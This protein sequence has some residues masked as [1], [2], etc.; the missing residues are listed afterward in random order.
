MAAYDRIECLLPLVIVENFAFFPNII[1]KL[2]ERLQI[3]KTIE[4]IASAVVSLVVAHPMR[5]RALFSIQI[6]HAA[7]MFSASFR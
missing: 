3:T 4:I 2:L 6:Y 1:D 5:A 7:F